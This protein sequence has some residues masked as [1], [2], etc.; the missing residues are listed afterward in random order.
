MPSIIQNICLALYDYTAQDPDELTVSENT[1]LLVLDASDPD[2]WR[3]KVAGD[4][5]QAHVGLVPSAYLEEV[6][7]NLTTNQV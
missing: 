6:I 2:W 7:T 5:E 3:V 4:E 1:V